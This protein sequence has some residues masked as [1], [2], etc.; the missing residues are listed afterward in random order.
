[1][2]K[3][4]FTVAQGLSVGLG[5]GRL[6]GNDLAR[7][8]HGVRIGHAALVGPPG[9][10]RRGAILEAE[11]AARCGA[12]LTALPVGAMFSHVTAARLW[13]LPLP[14]ARPEEPLHVAVCRPARPPRRPGVVGHVVMDSA[15]HIVSRARLP[16]ID[17]GLLF[18]QLATQLSLP[19]L[20]AV[21]D[22]LVLRPV[23]ADPGQLRPWLSQNA[24]N[25][26]IQS[27]RG[28]GKRRAL[29]AAELIR[30]GTESRPES[31]VRLVLVAAGLPEP[32]VQVDITDAG[33]R[34]FGRAD[35]AYRRWKVIVE[36]D[37]DQHRSTTA[38]F[39]KD[40]RRLDDFAALGWR[41]VRIVGR[42]FFPNPQESVDR[43]ARALVE[44]G[45]R[46]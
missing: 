45:W 37:G 3:A 15:A 33:G 41:V 13:P 44:R 11:L 29:R 34:W 6:R 2:E 5:Q 17:P 25:S 28:R 22:A 42:S 31:L 21:G 7:P 4:G 40:V 27:Y 43:V 18:C 39:D 23:Y 20:V 24:L 35:M 32:E 14:T 30:P 16:L 38:Q 26:R 46:P 8:F 10:T 19:D 36:Y 9:S 12:L 1:M